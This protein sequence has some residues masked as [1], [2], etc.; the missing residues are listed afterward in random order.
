MAGL[1]ITLLGGLRLR[2]PNQGTIELASQKGAQ[3][4]ALLAYAPGKKHRRDVLQALLWPDS[5]QPHAQGNLRF[6]LHQLRKHL[7]GDEGPL[8]SD[9]QSVGL[10]PDRIAVDVVHFEEL[11]E[12]G[13]LEALTAACDLYVGDLLSTAV[14]LSPEYEDWLLPERERFRELARA[15]FW[16]L[17]SLRLWRGEIGEAKVCAQRYLEIDPTC[18]RMHAALMRLHLMQG[19]RA[20]ALRRYDQLRVRLAQDHQIRPGADL[21]QLARSVSQSGGSPAPQSFDAA[22]ILGRRDTPA[23]GKPLVVV[24]PFQDLSED[25]PLA[26]LPAAL[27]EDVITDL[28]RFRRLAVLAR[29]TSFTIGRDPDAD[30]RLRQLGVRYSVEGSIRRTGNRLSVTARLVE[31]RSSQQ[32]WGERYQGDWD[33][34]PSFQEQVARAIVAAIPIQV[35]QA[36]LERVRHQEIPSLSSYEHCL[37]A[38]EHQRSTSHGSHTKALECFS[39]ALDQDPRSAAAHSGLALSMFLIG[40]CTRVDEEGRRLKTAIWHAQQAIELDPLDAQGHWTLGMLL[41]ML[42]EF[43]TARLHLDRAMTLSPGDAETLAYTGLEYAYAGDPTCGVSQS[44]RSIQLN[45][46]YP[47]AFV[48]LLGKS[49]FV[50]HRYEE[51]LFWLRQS[52]DR[53]ATNRAWLAAAAAYAGL[54]DEAER[55]AGVFMATLRQCVWQDS[56]RTPEDPISWLREPARFQYA[57]DLE[58]YEQGLKMAGIGRESP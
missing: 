58:H 12:E 4:L 23:T 14:D 11:A 45:P 46:S 33:E 29:H 18:E 8:L 51:A 39:R 47:P 24:I 42:R 55:H 28:S 7:G 44:Q 10:D 35:E 2:H 56:Q 22:W 13:T 40:G 48:E 16:N 49:C 27:T 21:E 20:L 38:R 54:R 37:L 52:P 36:E 30:S 6:V 3:L 9:N 5:D 57:A 53:V 32:V 25:R 31:N 19:G 15:A 41:Q 17:F 43:G 50:G 26:S 34:L 1:E